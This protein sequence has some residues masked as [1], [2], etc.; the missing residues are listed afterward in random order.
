MPTNRRHFFE[1]L[2]ASAVLAA[3]GASPLQAAQGRGSARD[4]FAF[5]EA[6]VPMN[7]ANL[8]P[9]PKRVAEAVIRYTTLIDADCS[10]QNRAQFRALTEASR[11]AVA[12]LLGVSA[13]EIAFVRNTSEA[14]NIVNAGLDLNT[15]DDVL[16]WDQNHP[17]NNVAWDVRAARSGFSVI[18]VAVPER[19]AKPDDLLA[20]FRAAL[21][22]RTAVL[23]VT[24]ISNVSGIRLPIEELGNMCRER[25]IHFHVDGA[26]TWGATATNLDAVGCDSFSASAHKWFLGPKEVGLL[27]LRESAIERLW[28]SVI[29]YGWGS[30][31]VSDLVGARKFESLGQRDDAALAALAEAAALHASL[32][33]D[34][35]EA[36]IQG[37]ASRLKEGLLE[38]GLSLVTPLSP[39]LSGGVCIA[40]IG[41][42]ARRPVFEALYRDHGIIGAPTGGLRL[43]PHIYNNE[44]HVDRAIAGAAEAYARLGKGFA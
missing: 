40:D 31:G 23:S 15:G 39:E 33:H 41:G 2:G 8:C 9:S 42:P 18:R 22:P 12:S 32:G 27:Y 7:A 14:N 25:G 38:R 43:C 20:P 4:G 10:F 37:L 21:T 30:D 36:H 1:L 34:R 5:D 28:P 13:D 35:V 11:S 19:P 3:A 24:H 29:S 26:Q 16:L 44:E 6:H 17:S